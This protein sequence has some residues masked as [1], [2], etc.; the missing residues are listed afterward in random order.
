MRLN[1]GRKNVKRVKF[2]AIRCVLSCSKR[3]KCCF[4]PGSAPDSAVGVYD[5][6]QSP[7]PLVGWAGGIGKTLHTSPQPTRRSGTVILN[8]ASDYRANGL[9][10]GLGLG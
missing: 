3:T 2:V 1:M 7:D 9:M 10:L 8:N 5:A 6:P 4:Q